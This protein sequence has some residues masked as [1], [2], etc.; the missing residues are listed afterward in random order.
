MSKVQNFPELKELF[1]RLEEV[2]FEGGTRL[3]YN[4][5]YENHDAEHTTLGWNEVG[6]LFE[7]TLAE[8][9]F[10]LLDGKY[11]SEGEGE[12]CYSVIKVKDKYFRAYWSYYSYHGCEY[13]YIED[14]LEEVKPV[15]K[16]I[17]VYETF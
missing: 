2:G 4:V 17:I 14:T 8:F 12:H 9:D 1:G 6:K 15:E 16:T 13:D 7:E 3:I 11:G 5:F 10:E